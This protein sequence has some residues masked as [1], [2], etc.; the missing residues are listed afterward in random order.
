MKTA[1]KDED[2]LK[3]P[4]RRDNAG[5]VCESD[6]GMLFFKSSIFVVQKAIGPKNGVEFRQGS[7][8]TI[9]SSLAMLYDVAN[10]DHSEA[11]KLSHTE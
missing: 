8:G 7:I 5:A 11:E 2:N 6:M 4:Q 3:I 10:F 1:P 9:I